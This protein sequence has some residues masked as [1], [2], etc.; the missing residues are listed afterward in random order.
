VGA[1]VCLEM[2][3]A[4]LPEMCTVVVGGWSWASRAMAKTGPTPQEKEKRRMIH[5]TPVDTGPPR[6]F[7]SGGS[8]DMVQFLI[9]NLL[10]STYLG[11]NHVGRDNAAHY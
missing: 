11:E 5:M 10:S 1:L 9:N 8:S 7:T 4:F 6:G 2:A 3:L